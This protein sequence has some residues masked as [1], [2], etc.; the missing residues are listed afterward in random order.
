MK[1]RERTTVLNLHPYS[2]SHSLVSSLYELVESRY[3]QLFKAVIVHGSIGNG[4]EIKYSD[5]DGLLVVKNTEWESTEFKSFVR[6]SQKLIL[7]YDPLQ[8]HGWFVIKE[9]QLTAYPQDYLPYQVL[10]NAKLIWPKT[11][12]SFTIELKE[13]YDFAR[14]FNHLSGHVLSKVERNWIPQNIYQLKSFLSEIMLLPCLL[15]TA[16]DQAP[17]LKELSFVEAEKRFP[18]FDWSA[19][20]TA[21]EIR[22]HWDYT[23]SG[24]QKALMTR[25]DRFWRKLTKKKV[26]PKVEKSLA[27]KLDQHYYQQLKVLIGQMKTEVNS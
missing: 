1:T 3:S 2:G 4:D 11:P 9:S 10:E 16:L 12:V 18:D 26:A 21:S 14:A 24:L 8:H 27:D 5:F 15:I 17:I 6:S 22:S 20:H 7:Q 13:Q 23:L 25:P 19:M